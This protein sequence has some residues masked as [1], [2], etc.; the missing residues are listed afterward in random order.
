MK[1]QGSTSAHAIPS[2]PDASPQAPIAGAPPAGVLPDPMV[3]LAASGDVAAM[4]SALL[5]EAGKN[6]RE[7]ARQSRDAAIAAEDAAHARKIEHME[8]AATQQLV[9]GIASG[10]LQIYSALA[11][12]TAPSDS[13]GKVATALLGGYDKLATAYTSYA[14]KQEEKEQARAE[15]ALT[16]AKRGV[17]A[18]IDTDKDAKD[19]IRRAMGYYADYLR[20]KDD[21]N[22]AALFR[23]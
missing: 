21:A 6:S 14:A 22:K 17:E 15:R 10:G 2:S 19:L 5:L 23:A 8:N 3:S 20:A 9:G 11:T 1:I 13:A 4:I 7:V 18:A 16:Q 12:A